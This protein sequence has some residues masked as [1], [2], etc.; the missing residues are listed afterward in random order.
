MSPDHPKFAPQP[1]LRAAYW[2]SSDKKHKNRARFFLVHCQNYPPD[3]NDAFSKHEQHNVAGR[4][5]ATLRSAAVAID[6]CIEVHANRTLRK[7]L[8]SN[9]KCVP[10]PE[11]AKRFFIFSPKGSH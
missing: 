5:S 1:M 2:C 8:K 7:S 6:Q 9:S 4:R 3:F 10:H 11:R